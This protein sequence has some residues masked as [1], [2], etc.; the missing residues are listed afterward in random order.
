ML[1]VLFNTEYVNLITFVHAHGSAFIDGNERF[2]KDLERYNL[3]KYYWGKIKYQFN[4]DSENPSIYDFL[5]DVFNAN[6]SLGNSSNIEQVSQGFVI[7]M[8]GYYS[9]QR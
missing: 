8:E 1:A 7:S 2:D 6:F 9:I 4:Y 3:T 5:I